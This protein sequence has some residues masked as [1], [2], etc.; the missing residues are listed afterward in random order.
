MAKAYESIV[1][2][3]V[4]RTMALIGDR[5]TALLLRDLL[6]HGPRRFRDF[7]ESLVGVAPTVLSSRLK[8]L[9]ANG[10]V[11][12]TLYNERPPRLEYQLTAYGRSLGPV[13]SAM[14]AWGLKN[15]TPPKSK[16]SARR[17]GKDSAG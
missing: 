17:T 3:P 11:S 10:F 1:D 4:A 5:W 7:E 2:C 12:R 9:E 6:L 16:P 15:P 14:R 13:I 8:A